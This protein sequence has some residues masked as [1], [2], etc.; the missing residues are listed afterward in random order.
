MA[1]WLLYKW[2]EWCKLLCNAYLM[3]KRFQ[4]QTKLISKFEDILSKI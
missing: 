3:D 1:K 4:N 2:Y